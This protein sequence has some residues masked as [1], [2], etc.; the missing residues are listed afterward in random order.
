MKNNINKIKEANISDNSAIPGVGDGKSSYLQKVT[1]RA[2]ARIT[3]IDDANFMVLQQTANEITKGHEE[4]LEKLAEKML[5]YLFKGVLNHQDTNVELD[6]KLVKNGEEVSNMLDEMAKE[7]SDSNI[8]NN[9]DSYDEDEDED[10][11]E[12]SDKKDPKY[13]VSNKVIDADSIKKETDKRKIANNIIQGEAKNTKKIL[14]MPEFRDAIREILGERADEAISAW[15]KM[16]DLADKMDWTSDPKEKLHAMMT[17]KGGF[18][19]ASGIIYTENEDGSVNATMVDIEDDEEEDVSFDFDLFGDDDDDDSGSD[20]D[21]GSDDESGVSE[22]KAIIR[23]IGVDLIMLLHEGVKG[24]YEYIFSMGLP[25]DPILGEIVLNNT[26]TFEDEIEDFKFGPEIA[27]DVRNY[28][29]KYHDINKV[30]NLRELIYAMMINL[31]ADEFLSLIKEILLDVPQAMEKIEEL[32]KVAIESTLSDDE[33]N[34]IHGD[35]YDDEDDSKYGSE[36]EDEYTLPKQ[37]DSDIV[38]QATNIINDEEEKLSK[39]YTKLLKGINQDA[40]LSKLDSADKTEIID[41]AV[42][43]EEYEIAQLVSKTITNESLR[44]IIDKEILF[45]INENRK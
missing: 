12:P 22:Y 40:E 43:D 6:V 44:T 13:K 36:E 30:D 10:E 32:A 8:D 2:K 27:T 3:E 42:S 16:S 28:V 23:V 41:M 29:N 21:S 24:I 25:T 17:M 38:K 45:A 11:L 1:N 37:N 19:G 31:P 4:E 35:K 39:I 34:I 14:V 9:E 7:I 33:Y 26:D 5:K 20:N 18:L 15:V